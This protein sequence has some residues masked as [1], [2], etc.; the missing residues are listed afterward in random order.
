MNFFNASVDQYDRLFYR[1]LQ[2]DNIEEY[3]KQDTPFFERSTGFSASLGVIG[4]L[5][6]NFRL[7]ASLETPTFW[8]IDRTYDFYNDPVY[9]D[10]R[11]AESRK[12]TS[13][14]KA[15]VSA[16]FVASKNFSLNVDY[17]LGLT[18]PDY[19]VYGSAERELNDFFKDNYKNLSEVRVGAEYRVQQFRLRGDMLISQVRLMPLRSADL[20][21]TGMQ[22]I[23]LTAI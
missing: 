15:T 17:T 9:G 11:G 19:K 23:S 5:S 22:V 20:M 1:T 2:T 8:N 12:L 3:R 10:D 7:G 18:K 6:P 4:K 16:A 14:L 13:P 21:Q